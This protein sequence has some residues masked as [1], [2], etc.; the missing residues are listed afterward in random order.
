M[1]ITRITEKN[2]DAFKGLLPAAAMTARHMALGYVEDGSACGAL[3]LEYGA[4]SATLESV[5]V[6]AER[7]RSGI[8]SRLIDTACRLLEKTSVKRLGAAVSGLENAVHGNTSFLMKNLFI[9][10]RRSPVFTLRLAD[11]AACELLQKMAARENEENLLPLRSVTSA[12]IKRFNRMLTSGANYI[13]PA[14]DPNALDGDCSHFSFSD[15]KI[16]GCILFSRNADDSLPLDWLYAVQAKPLPKLLA[17]G[18]K[19]ATTAYSEDT[20]LH[21]AIVNES[22][23]NIFD[24]LLGDCPKEE[25]VCAGLSRLIAL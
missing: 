19:A 11:I 5:A 8:G 15:G 9:E 1:G 21:I 13:Y 20:S 6:S 4:Y 25:T 3:S 17:A 14:I 12:H 23:R 10:E 7:R 22:A 16:D 24:H 2:F 18:L